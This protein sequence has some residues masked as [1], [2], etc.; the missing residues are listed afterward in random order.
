[1]AK[2]RQAKQ[3][4]TKDTLPVVMRLWREWVKPHRMSLIL[5]LALVILIAVTTSLYPVLV[6][7]ALD[8]F[9]EKNR[10]VILMAP[11]LII[12]ITAIKGFSLLAQTVLTNKVVSQIEADMQI[13]LYSHLIDGDL[14]QIGREN[15]ATLTQRF[16][17]DFAFIKEA[18]TRLSTVFLRDVATIIAVVI[19]MLW[20]DPVLTLASAVV[21]P[22]VA[23]PI[24]KI[25][26]KLRRMSTSTQEQVG[27]M[28]GLVSES[29]QGARV[30]KT[31]NLEG[32]LKG[33]ATTAFDD[34]RILKMKAANARGRL[35][36]LLEIAGG[37]ALAGVFALIGW[38]IL[39]GQSSVG[40]FVGF[41]TALLLASQPI[42]ALGNLSAIVQEAVAALVR[43]FA[44]TD[45]KPTILDAPDAKLLAIGSGEICFDHVRFR[46]R[47]D[48]IALDGVTLT[49][50]A[51]KTTALVGRSGSGKSTMI[52]L[53]PRLYDVSEGE[54]R[55]D[56]QDIRSVTM[57][58]LRD[59]VSVVSQDVVLFDDTIRANIAFGR[60]NATNEEIMAAAKAAAA[61]DFIMK[62]P[63]GYDSRVGPMGTRLSG[64]ERQRVS[65][66][67]AF[68]KDAPILLLDEATSALDS[69]SE[70]LVQ[71]AIRKLMH[72]RTTLVIAH[73][74]STVRDAD[75]IVVM[76]GGKII[77][78]GSH[79]ALLAKDG[80]YAR[81]H[82][83]Q[84][85]DDSVTA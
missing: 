81:L 40:D 15:A 24:A 5:I 76:E 30:A 67:R 19:A 10:E 26:R 2:S 45:E 8:A 18:L 72:G 54:V 48:V 68:L 39:A 61:H 4:F 60:E 53:V 31:Y 43:Y 84:L 51:G 64:G 66:A 1:M 27:A 85:T 33:K 32:Y 36:P 22:F 77:E 75:T 44:I 41:V 20:I 11:V 7:M 6:K 73:R 28:A 25:G 52:S 80:A 82:R 57:H 3:T 74:L 12:V 58:S 9:T 34:I 65:L 42:R 59:H 37:V 63:E 55:I 17:T 78:T 47:D 13:K 70:R 83:L 23:P 14:A 38:R 21:A 62:M 16:T 79:E 50:A 46:Y 71:K 29:L 56:G 35:D 69:E 49:A